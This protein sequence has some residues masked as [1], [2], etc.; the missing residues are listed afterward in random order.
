MKITEN[1]KNYTNTLVNAPLETAKSRVNLIS[2]AGQRDE[3]KTIVQP[4][5]KPLDRDLFAYSY[6][7]DQVVLGEYDS[8]ERKKPSIEFKSNPTVKPEVKPAVQKESGLFNTLYTLLKQIL[9]PQTAN[10]TK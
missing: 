4:T 3:G 10:S 6:L 9:L 2:F 8:F 1:I 5:L 7:E